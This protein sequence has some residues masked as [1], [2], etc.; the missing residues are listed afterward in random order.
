MK[1]IYQE[2]RKVLEK[3][4]DP[5]VKTGCVIGQQINLFFGV[6]YFK[7]LDIIITTNCNGQNFNRKKEQKGR[8]WAIMCQTLYHIYHEKYL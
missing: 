3:I 5:L 1:Q 6:A 4:P 2:Q 8:N 7:P